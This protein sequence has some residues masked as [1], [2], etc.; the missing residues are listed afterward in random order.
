M[1]NSI[2]AMVNS[3]TTTLSENNP[4][5]Y[6]FG[7]VV[8]NDFKLGWSDIDIICLTEK[9]LSEDQAQGLV[10]LRQTLL[11][12]YPDNVY[13]GLFEGGILSIN[14]F[15]NKTTDRVVYWGTSGQ[16]ITDTYELDPFSKIEIKDSGKLLYGR[17]FKDKISY[18]TKDEIKKAIINHYET[19]RKY[20]RE[21][22][23]RV[24]STGW[25]LD[26]ARCLYTLK[27]EKVIAKT[28]AG[29]WA[30]KEN[31]VPDIAIMKRAIE[32]R[33]N[34]NFFKTDVDTLNW[35]STLGPYIQRFADVLE[36]QLFAK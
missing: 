16:R 8:L 4:N 23:Q 27:T 9:V 18:P 11:K 28:D 5:I 25:L 19:I 10:E 35:L 7:S 21:T 6:L 33:K 13:Y 1:E 17:D 36:S 15:L 24:T 31:L 34:P 29:E 32:V 20:A 2:N 12:E 30:I 14:A 3:I 22:N 26:I